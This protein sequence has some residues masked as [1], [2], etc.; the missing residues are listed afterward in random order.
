M[1]GEL[2]ENCYLIEQNNEVLIVDPGAEAKRIETELEGK[3]VVGILITHHHFDHVGALDKLARIYQ[4]PVIDAEIKE[5]TIKIGSFSFEIVRTPGHSS[6]S[7]SYYFALRQKMFVGDFVFAGTIGRTD[8]ET[9]DMNEMKRSL[10]KLKKYPSTIE[11]YPGHGSTTTLALEL[12]Y[13]P[14]MK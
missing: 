1:V 14:F 4:V 6:D 12:R 9:G 13:N 3:H 11:L 8:L 10:E 7:I 5:E 2:E